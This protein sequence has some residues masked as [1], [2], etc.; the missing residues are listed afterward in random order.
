MRRSSVSG[1]QEP[2]ASRSLPLTGGCSCGAIRCK[3][4]P[5]PLLLYSQLHRSPDR[6]G[7]PDFGRFACNACDV[8]G[9]L[10]WKI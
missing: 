1:L 9:I 3:I 8:A 5:F 4:A 10:P 6:I 7:P 2:D